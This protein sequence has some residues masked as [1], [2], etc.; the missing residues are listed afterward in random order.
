M[1]QWPVSFITY[2][3]ILSLKK[4]CVWFAFK[5]VIWML[6]KV[7]MQHSSRKPTRENFLVKSLGTRLLYFSHSASTSKATCKA[8]TQLSALRSAVIIINDSKVLCDNSAS[9]LPALAIS[10]SQTR[11]DTCW[12]NR[13]D[14]HDPSRV[15]K[16]PQ[17]ARCSPPT[18]QQSAEKTELRECKTQREAAQTL[19]YAGAVS[20]SD[21]T[22][23]IRVRS[24]RARTAQQLLYLI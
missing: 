22:E 10:Q 13:N 9:A 16:K 24:S 23:P 18:C 15:I 14:Q 3:S 21:S 4:L 5:S 19:F 7:C 11:R 12:W 1:R 8:S 20:V 17:A 6:L 2:V